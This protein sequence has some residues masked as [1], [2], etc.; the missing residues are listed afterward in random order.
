MDMEVIQ[1][2]MYFIIGEESGSFSLKTFSIDTPGPIETLHTERP[3]LFYYSIFESNGHVQMMGGYKAQWLQQRIVDQYGTVLWEATDERVLL[4]TAQG[5][6]LSELDQNET[7]RTIGFHT[8]TAG[9]YQALYGIANSEPGRGGIVANLFQTS[10]GVLIF[11]QGNGIP[12]IKDLATG[13]TIPGTMFLRQKDGSL[14]H[15]SDETLITGEAPVYAVEDET[16][17]WFAN[18]FTHYGTG[19]EPV[20]NIQHMIWK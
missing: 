5:N 13:N 12:L 20:N 10:K 11:L 18:L 8:G 2:K 19:T 15:L 17:M 4:H 9:S 16:G 6:Y 14:T 7:V 3:E 1:N